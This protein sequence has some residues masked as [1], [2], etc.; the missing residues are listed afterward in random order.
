MIA[1]SF[2]EFAGKRRTSQERIEDALRSE[3]ERALDGGI[4][5]GGY[6]DLMAAVRREWSSAYE[7]ESG[8][9]RAIPQRLQDIFTRTLRKA[10]KAT[11]DE[12]TVARITTW[13]ATAIISSSTVEAAN[14]DPEEIFLEWVD[15]NDSRVRTSHAVASG[16]VRPLGE[17]FKVGDVEMPYPGYPGVDIEEWINCRC[18]V[19]QVL[20]S[21]ALVAAIEHAKGMRLN[22][23]AYDPGFQRVMTYD[24][25]AYDRSVSMLERINRGISE[26]ILSGRAFA[27]GGMV[28]RNATGRYGNPRLPIRTSPFAHDLVWL[29]NR[30]TPKVVKKGEKYEP[31]DAEGKI[32]RRAPA[33]EQDEKD[34]ASGDWVRKNEHGDKPGDPGYKRKKSKVRPGPH[35]NSVIGLDGN[36]GCTCCG[37]RGEHRDGHECYIC[38]ASGQK[39]AQDEPVNDGVIYCEGH[40]GLPDD[41][42]ENAKVRY[43]EDFEHS[44]DNEVEAADGY[45]GVTHAGLAVWAHDTERI[46]MMQRSLDPEDAPEVQGTWEFPGGGLEEGEDPQAAA[47]REFTEETGLAIPDGEIVNGWR[48]PNGVYQGFVLAVDLESEAFDLLNPESVEVSNPDDPERARPEVCAWFTIEQIQ[49]LGVALRP[50]CAKM[51][52]SVFDRPEDNQ[53]DDMPEDTTDPEVEA[54][55][56]PPAEP[57]ECL[58]RDEDGNCIDPP[59]EQPTQPPPFAEGETGQRVPF[60]SVLAPEG[61]WSGDRRRFREGSLSNRPLPLPITW[62]KISDDGHKGNVVVAVCDRIAV[63]DGEQR[64]TGWMLSTPEADEVM[65]V[66]AEF[67]RFGISVDADSAQFEMNEEEEGMDFTSARTSSAC[68]VTIPAF[69]EAWFALGQAPEG[70]L[71]D[72]EAEVLPEDAD[73][74]EEVAALVAS[75]ADL[76]PGRTEDGPGWLTNPVDTD[77]LRDYW[78]KGEGAAKIAWGT[79]GDFRRCRVAVAQYIKPQYLNG[80]CANRHFDATG[81]WPGQQSSVDLGTSTETPAVSLTASAGRLK[82]DHRLL[83]DPE[84]AVGDGRMV[85]D[86]EGNWACPVTVTDDGQ[87]FGHI[88]GWK[89]CHGNWA[90]DGI[91]ITAPHSATN[92]AHFLTSQIETDLGPVPVGGLTYGGGHAPDGL[93]ARAAANHYDSTS[94]VW[95]YVNV[96]EDQFGIWFSGVLK[97]GLTQAALVEATAAPLSGD[98][99]LRGAQMEMIAAHSVVTPGFSIPR[100]A[101]GVE[102]GEQISLVAAGVLPPRQVA[103]IPEKEFKAMIKAAVEQGFAEARERRAEM[104]RIAESVEAH[105]AIVDIVNE[106]E[107]IV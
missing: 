90:E 101:C 72:E 32:T 78:T 2:E 63:V 68:L 107:R 77:R 60:H 17:D 25:I 54:A 105:A 47:F 76:A 5:T 20:A 8:S 34:I 93:R 22:E 19:R 50:E 52:W 21:E 23:V 4:N 98:W 42:P 69:A 14:D 84:F 38:E 65:G 87:V 96:G 46:L 53:E 67:G 83:K 29:E 48:S 70:F 94:S 102:N 73:M 85:Q 64:A 9:R 37:G 82:F 66:V 31:T 49:N 95:A 16:Q 86:R 74:E 45:E 97:P 41:G 3:V 30:R 24:M 28:D 11:S 26:R 57:D 71:P 80:Y 81:T 6:G 62:Q 56:M 36:P 61:V 89:T 1:L 99:R 88:A 58:E 27:K 103:E 75:F 104:A 33:S 106:I 13:L 59:A 40:H 100:V 15:M 7:E 43:G 51:D 12:N 39:A 44:K 92:Y 79:P 35:T 91:C 18:T 10:D 55:A